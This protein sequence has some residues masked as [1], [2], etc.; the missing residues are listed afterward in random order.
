MLRFAAVFAFLAFVLPA[1][2]Q[3]S[4][5][6]V[7][8]SALSPTLGHR[9][10]PIPAGA[11]SPQ[12]FPFVVRPFPSG[13][14]VRTFNL[15]PVPTFH[16]FGIHKHNQFF[17]QV[18]VFYPIYAPAYDPFAYQPVA[19]PMVSQGV[20][21]EPAPDNEA[22][23]VRSEDALRQAY[24]QGARDA[25]A[26]EQRGRQDARDLMASRSAPPPVKPKVADSEAKPSEPDDSPSTVFIFKD[27]RQIETKNYAIMG[28][29]LYDISGPVV[30][31]IQLADLD[32][33]ATIK[34]NDDR[35]ITVK[36]P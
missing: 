32:A 13:R 15:Q 8:A 7:P 31:K 2:A 25:L 14:V 16:Q 3:I 4:S 36:L 35:G 27:G 20:Q 11:T 17:P 29:T 1:A 34:A 5:T 28:Q 22:A 33:A 30:K 10:I 19:D 26:E 12:G 21:P 23:M 24:L 9:T 6:G 18:P